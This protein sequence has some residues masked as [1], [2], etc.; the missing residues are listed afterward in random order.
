MVVRSFMNSQEINTAIAE[1]EVIVSRSGYSMVMDLA[2]MEKKAIFIPTP[3]QTEQEYLAEE[4]MKRQVAFSMNQSSFNLVKAL[5]ETDKFSGFMKFEQ[6]D[7]LLRN[8]IQ[9]IL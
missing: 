1:S 8:A 4:L 5:K 2:K 7:S 6:D 9:S 3:G